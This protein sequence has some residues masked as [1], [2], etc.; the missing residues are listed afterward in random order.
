MN[1]IELKKGRYQFT[2]IGPSERK[3]I[4]VEIK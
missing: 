3:I 2:L 4:E 1:E